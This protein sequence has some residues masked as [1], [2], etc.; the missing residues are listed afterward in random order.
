LASHQKHG[1]RAGQVRWLPRRVAPRELGRGTADTV[2]CSRN[3]RGPAIAPGRGGSACPGC[4][5]GGRLQCGGGVSTFPCPARIHRITSS[6]NKQ[7]MPSYPTSRHP[8]NESTADPAP[9]QQPVTAETLRTGSCGSRTAHPPAGFVVEA[10]LHRYAL[11]CPL[12]PP[13]R[14]TGLPAALRLVRACGSG[15]DRSF[16]A[17]LPHARRASSRRNPA[18]RQA[19]MEHALRPA[20]N[21]AA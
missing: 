12:Q 15:S 10:G 11:P 6:A 19:F 3:P 14:P 5:A 16:A 20:A 2:G 18:L 7:S 17:P 1:T 4:S 21:R 8:S 13:P 9:P